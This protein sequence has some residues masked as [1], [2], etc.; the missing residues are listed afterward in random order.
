MDKK[1]N[2]VTGSKTDKSC[3]LINTSENV[4]FLFW[5][6]IPALISAIVFG[7]QSEKQYLKYSL[8]IAALCFIFIMLLKYIK[9]TRVKKTIAN[10]KNYFTYKIE[11]K[12]YNLDSPSKEEYYYINSK[13]TSFITLCNKF[14]IDG[15]GIAYVIRDKSTISSPDSKVYMDQS[16]SEEIRIYYDQ[17][18][19]LETGRVLH[20]TELKQFL[21]QE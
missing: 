3:I 16:Y 9:R 14:L 11:G 6:G 1:N 10:N 19:E 5:I 2:T 7:F 8:L 15:N 12:I 17:I 13:E 18:T 21:K 20:V 4:S